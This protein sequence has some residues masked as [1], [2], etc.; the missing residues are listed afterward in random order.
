MGLTN[1]ASLYDHIEGK[2]VLRTSPL[3]NTSIL[4]VFLANFLEGVTYDEVSSEI[5]TD[6]TPIQ[7][8]TIKNQGSVV[9]VLEVT[10][11]GISWG[12]IRVPAA[13]TSDDGFELEADDGQF[14]TED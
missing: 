10:Y 14:I 4:A 11:N 1:D 7:L 2:M 9:K 8:I 12:L 5:S 3:A 13:I 6:K